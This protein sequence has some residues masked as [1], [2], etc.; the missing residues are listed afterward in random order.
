MFDHHLTTLLS[1][2]RFFFLPHQEEEK[3]W[4]IDDIEK[5]SLIFPVVF[6]ISLFFRQNVSIGNFAKAKGLTEFPLNK[7]ELLW[8]F[9]EDDHGAIRFTHI[10]E[11]LICFVR[12]HFSD[13]V[14]EHSWMYVQW[15]VAHQSAHWFFERL[16]RGHIPTEEELVDL[17]LAKIPEDML[18]PEKSFWARMRLRG[19][20]L[21]GRE[22]FEN[23]VQRE[24]EK[25][26]R[27]NELKEEGC[28]H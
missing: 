12:N 21:K 19:S 4:V 11:K 13:E 25:F 26:Q 23:I 28:F 1:P 15:F 7:I 24:R 5:N 10:H 20:M 22:E 6:G 8:L 16:A 3:G 2:S 18:N 9:D 17:D 14:L 27:W